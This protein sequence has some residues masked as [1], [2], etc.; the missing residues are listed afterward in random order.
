LGCFGA[1]P[2]TDRAE[3]PSQIAPPSSGNLGPLV[4]MKNMRYI[5]SLPTA[6]SFDGKG[7][8]GYTFGPLIQRIVEIYY[9]EVEIHTVY[10][11][12]ADMGRVICLRLGL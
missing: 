2:G 9:I 5:Y 8:F 3:W 7:L 4:K 6:R 11:K 1:T 10:I 12:L